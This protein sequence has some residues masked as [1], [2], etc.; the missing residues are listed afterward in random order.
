MPPKPTRDDMTLAIM[1]VLLDPATGCAVSAKLQRQ[2]HMR[3]TRALL[4]LA[5]RRQSRQSGD[6]TARV[7]EVL[8]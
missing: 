2:R 7:G 4:T 8:Q 3:D 1:A 6:Q 5:R